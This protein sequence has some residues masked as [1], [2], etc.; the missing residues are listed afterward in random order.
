MS[1]REEILKIFET[2]DHWRHLPA[3]QIERRVDIFFAMYLPYALEACCNV[4]IKEHLVPEFPIKKKY[5]HRSYKADYLAIS[6][7]GGRA[8]LIELKTDMKSRRK[9]QDDAYK[10]AE[11]MGLRR[12][13]EEII[14]IRRKT[15]QQRKYGELLDLLAKLDIVCPAAKR[16]SLFSKQKINEYR[17]MVEKS[18]PNIEIL[19]IQ[20]E[21]SSTNNVITF[22]QFADAIEGRGEVA[23]LF[24]GYLRRWAK[25]KAGDQREESD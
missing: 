19:Y 12:L 4:K 1:A 22:Y 11:N 6:K 3:Y 10:R 7:D 17:N 15:K 18:E 16:K 14:R 24:A 8:F 9:K 5:S 25:I 20:P 2:L 23:T 13:V 21:S